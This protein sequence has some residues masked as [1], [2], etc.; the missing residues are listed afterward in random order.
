[1]AKL[2][3]DKPKEP[4]AGSTG[5]TNK[6]WLEDNGKLPGV[7][8]TASGLQYQ[9]L[10]AGAEGGAKPTTADK[11]QVAYKGTLLDGSQFDAN[12]SCEFAVTG[13]IKGWTEALQL[14]KPGDKWKLFIPPELGY[15]EAGSPP[16]IGANA[17][18]TFE[19]EL[20]AIVK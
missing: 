14:M 8:T 15:G 16:K 6:Q 19:V 9:V 12:E 7:T 20:K 3:E 10:S 5:K 13:V 11:V 2:W 18:L 4:M 17:I 1:V